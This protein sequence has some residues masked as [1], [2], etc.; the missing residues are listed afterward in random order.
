MARNDY[1]AEQRKAWG[2][3]RLAQERAAAA[4][5]RGVHSA[6][7]NALPK[8][9][10]LVPRARVM[11]GA[12][13]RPE[14]TPNQRAIFAK[15]TR[16]IAEKVKAKTNTKL[17][18]EAARKQSAIDRASARRAPK[19]STIHA[20]TPSS[21]FASVSYNKADEICTMEFWR[22]GAIVYDEPMSLDEFLDFAESNSLGL[23]FND[24]IR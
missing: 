3:A 12:E 2:A 18:P 15:I 14:Y 24:E 6:G 7:I 11:I 16:D 5:A 10:A 21:C 4:A 17:S 23:Y 8:I 13:P 20:T 9:D 22:G 19:N 1:T